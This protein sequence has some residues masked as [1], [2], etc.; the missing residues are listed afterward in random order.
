MIL[1][2]MVINNGGSC[3]CD[4][5]WSGDEGRSFLQEESG[6]SHYISF[7]SFSAYALSES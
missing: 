4:A 3:C 1:W 7:S 5:V 2:F 6:A